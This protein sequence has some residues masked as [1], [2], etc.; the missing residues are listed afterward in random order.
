VQRGRATAWPQLAHAVHVEV[1]GLRP[2][3]WYWYRFYTGS[4]VSPIGRTRTLAAP[5]GAVDR[6]RFAFA[7]CQHYETGY[8]TAYRHMSG[9]DLDLVFHL[10]DYIYED[11][12][13]TTQIRMHTGGELQS[14]DDYRSRYALYRLDPDLQA[15]HA[16][17]PWIVTMDDHEVDNDWAGDLHERGAERETFRLRRGAA[18]RAYYEHMPLRRT[19]LPA[20]PDMQLYRSFVHGDLA[21][22][23]VLDTR[24][25]RTD[26]PCGSG[27]QPPC[28][29]SLD[30]GATLLGPA[31]EGWLFDGLGRSASRWNVLPQ[32]VMMAKVD[33]AAGD[34]LA[35]SM[36]QWPGYDAALTRMLQFLATARPSNPVV[37]TGDIHA[38]YV[39]DLKVDFRDERSPIVGTELV[40]TSI[41]SGGN[42]SDLPEGMKHITS[43]NPFVK[44]CNGQ[45]GYVSCDLSPTRLLAHYRTL[46]YVTQP[47]APLQTRAS[48]VIENGRPG[49]QPA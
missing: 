10:G 12:G 22:F 28:P 47:G 18:F 13:R 34:N 43:E 20:G 35:L 8:Y 2:E 41:S 31:Q 11:A 33:R 23:F 5:G 44:F 32:Q 25:Y 38:N 46:E 15:A 48:F 6:L 16:A 36:D 21:A 3:R 26:Q 40:G 27:N 45:R 19:S 9:E 4:V 42:G 30:P 7:S 14:L 37:L 39:N 24:Q 49:A 17:C 29:A 1:D